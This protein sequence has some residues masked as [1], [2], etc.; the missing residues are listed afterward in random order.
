MT[1]N[2]SVAETAPLIGRDPLIAS[3]NGLPTRGADSSLKRRSPAC[4]SARSRRHKAAGGT[5]MRSSSRNF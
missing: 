3:V 5:S 1:I 2:R 4:A